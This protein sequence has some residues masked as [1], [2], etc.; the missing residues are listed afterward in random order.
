MID[1]THIALNRVICPELGLEEFFK[2]TASSG[3][4]K[5]ELRNDLS[6]KGIVDEWSPS[7][8]RELAAHYGIEIITINALQ[9]FNLVSMRTQLLEDLQQLI[10]LASSI[11]CPAIVLCPNNDPNDRRHMDQI[12]SETEE[13]LRSFAPLF[14]K[15]QLI[16]L[17]EPLGFPQSSLGSLPTAMEIIRASGCNRFKVVHDTFHHYLGPDSLQSLRESYEI[18]YTG[19]VHISG[20]ETDKPEEQYLDGDRVLVGPKDKL[21]SREQLRFLQELGYSG[22]VSFEPFSEKIQSL[23]AG[24]MADVIKASVAYLNG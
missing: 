5:V 12:R 20:V 10:D 14:E 6:G 9:K 2:L 18:D 19:L 3:L 11:R 17:V 4:G 8:V 21:G 23:S 7:S 22:D 1:T 13:N 16:G 15:S 24:K